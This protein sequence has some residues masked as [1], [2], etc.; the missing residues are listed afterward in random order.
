MESTNHNGE[1]QLLFNQRPHDGANGYYYPD[2]V[3]KRGGKCLIVNGVNDE[4]NST[5]EIEKLKYQ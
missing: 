3:D 1:D 5:G 2:N 4:K